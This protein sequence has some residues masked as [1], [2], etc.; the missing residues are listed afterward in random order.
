MRAEQVPD[1][2]RSIADALGTA[3][4]IYAD[5]LREAAEALE[6]PP[7]PRPVGARAQGMRYL[8]SAR[9]QLEQGDDLDGARGEPP[10]ADLGD[11]GRYL[12]ERTTLVGRAVD[13]L[14]DAVHVLNGSTSAEARELV[15]QQEARERQ[16]GLFDRTD[17]AT[18]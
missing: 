6:V 3:G 10:F 11:V 1:R 13:D 5:E 18:S 2:L 17:G 15:E 14:I 4:G 9:T 16:A 8:D 12:A 7:A